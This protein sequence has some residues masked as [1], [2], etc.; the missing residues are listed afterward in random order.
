M[1]ELLESSIILENKRIR[2]EPLTADNAPLLLNIVFEPSLWKFIPNRVTTKEDFD[3]YIEL[4]LDDKQK[5]LAYPFIVTD[6][7]SGKVVGSTRYGNISVKDKRVE[8]GWTWYTQA[9]QKTGLNRACK[10]E[11]LKFAF[12][13]LNCNRVELK[14]SFLNEK[15]RKA[16]AGIGATQE[17]IFRQHIINSDGTI[18]DTVYFSIIKS[19]WPAIKETIFKEWS[20]AE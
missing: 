9:V 12:E 11:L 14:T 3:N 15:S 17:G 13:K 16:I 5:G 7:Q 18:R 8:I 1:K 4:T 20:E 2:L 10:Y 19:E 6:K